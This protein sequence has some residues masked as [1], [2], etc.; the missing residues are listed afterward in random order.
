MEG[1][2]QRYG[3]VVLLTI[4][5]PLLLL[6]LDSPSNRDASQE[7]VRIEVQQVVLS[8]EYQNLRRICKNLPSYAES[9]NEIER[10]AHIEKE[11]LQPFHNKVVQT[12]FEHLKGCPETV[13]Y[14]QT[15]LQHEERV[16][17]YEASGYGG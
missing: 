14:I 8:R 12:E 4:F 2:V 7:K 10:I 9:I 1:Q 16:V 11:F 13:Q 3:P 15:L 5:S 6:I 17:P